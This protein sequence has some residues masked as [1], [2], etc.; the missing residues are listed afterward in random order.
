MTAPETAPGPA[1]ARPCDLAASDS[2]CPPDGCTGHPAAPVGA[3][4]A[5]SVSTRLP[6][7]LGDVGRRT[8][9]AGWPHRWVKA[10]AGMSGTGGPVG[11]EDL[12]RPPSGRVPQWV[13]DEQ[14]ARNTPPPSL[15]AQ[16][17]RRSRR[18]RTGKTGRRRSGSWLTA[19]L[20]VLLAAG[21]GIL[22]VRSGHLPQAP[23]IQIEGVVAGQR[24]L[25]TGADQQVRGRQLIR[26]LGARGKPARV[27]LSTHH[28]EMRRRGVGPRRAPD[29]GLGIYQVWV[30]T[31]WS[32]ADAVAAGR[33]EAVDRVGRS[34]GVM[35]IA[36]TT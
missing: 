22:A 5:M 3:V 21:V 4:G 30:A 26:V 11:P 19:G 32:G 33:A 15:R 12:P 35:P 27:R 23:S 31:G 9:R 7:R 8:S 17:P 34:S 29:L 36:M 13:L 1:P 2:H 16:R 20:P 14:R 28:H 6:V 25:L 10:G 24:E 18:P